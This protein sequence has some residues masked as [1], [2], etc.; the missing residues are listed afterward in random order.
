MSRSGRKSLISSEF[1]TARKTPSAPAAGVASSAIVALG[2]FVGSGG[3]QRFDHELYGYA[4][5]ATLAAF[6]VGY[7]FTL[8]SSRPPSR[9]Y[10]LRG[11]Q[12]IARRGPTYRKNK[13]KKTK[14]GY[15]LAKTA[16]Q[17]FVAQNFIRERSYYRWIMHLCLSGGCTLAFAVT[18]P[19]VFGWIHFSTPIDNAELYHVEVFGVTVDSFGIHSFKAAIMF[20][21][22]NIAGVFAFVGVTMAGYRRIADA[23]AR[24]LTTFYEDVLPL[25]IIAA[26]TITGLA[27]TVSYKFLDGQGHG[28][29]AWIHMLTVVALLFY[30]PFGKLFHMFQRVAAL[31]VSVY[32]KA[33]Q[34]EEQATCEATGKEFASQ[35]HVDDLKIVLDE[36]GFDYR[37]KDEN[38]KEVHYADISPEGRRRLLAFSQGKPLNR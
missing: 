13:S 19:L 20:N 11:L 4:V 6:A 35:R 33:G 16:S 15:E 27:L 7:R 34:A 25:I 29:L 18:F 28:S 31:C 26:V 14:P 24:A 23:G 12:L 38:G 22:L 9:M 17:N 36:L 3:M 2:I 5:A 1:Q 30:L 37:F 32:K 21:L 8:W 10:F